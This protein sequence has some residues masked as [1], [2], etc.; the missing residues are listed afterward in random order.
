MVQ[1]VTQRPFAMLL[2]A[3]KTLKANG[4]RASVKMLRI[5]RFVSKPG[6]RRAGRDIN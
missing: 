2:V 6:R 5:T 4:S 3:A 1:S